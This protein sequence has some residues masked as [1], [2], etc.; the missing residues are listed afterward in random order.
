MLP[1]PQT[2][3]HSLQSA[4]PS[5]RNRVKSFQ[6]INQ[7]TN[8]RTRALS[9]PS[10]LD[11]ANQDTLTTVEFAGSLPTKEKEARRE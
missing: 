2:H 10:A 11:V 9:A 4:P 8:N 3:P 1:E 5:F 6:P 7:V